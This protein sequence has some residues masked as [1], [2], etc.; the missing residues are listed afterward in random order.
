MQKNWKKL[1]KINIKVSFLQI[2]QCSHQCCY[3]YSDIMLP[4]WWPTDNIV[5]IYIYLV[6][7]V[8]VND[9]ITSITWQWFYLDGF[10][11]AQTPLSSTFVYEAKTSTGSREVS[12]CLSC[13]GTP[14]GCSSH[15]LPRLHRQLADKPTRWQTYSLTVALPAIL[16]MRALTLITAKMSVSY[17]KHS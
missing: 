2:H 1:S 16:L 12:G 17:C 6:E 5:Y 8:G 13:T 10:C 9:L 11:G 14:R 15:S 4:Q 3:C 7:G